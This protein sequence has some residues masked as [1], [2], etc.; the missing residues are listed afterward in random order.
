MIAELPLPILAK[1]TVARRLLSNRSAIA[2][3]A[4][5]LAIIIPCV[6]APLFAPYDPSVQP[7]IIGLRSQGPTVAHPFGTDPFSRDVLS[8]VLYGGRVSL[9]VALVATLVSITL[10]TAYGAIAGF[11]GGVV[12]SVMMRILDGLLSIPRLLLLIAIFAAWRQLPPAAFV[13]IIGLTGWYGLS[14]IVRGQVLAMK[15]EEFVVS[16]RALGAG[17]AR[18]LLRHILPNIL[19]PVIVAAALG[20]GHVI[21]L[22]A[23]LSYLGIGVQQP[24]PSWGN[25]IQDGSDQIAGQWWISFFPGMAIVLTVMAFNVL[26]DALREALQPRHMGAE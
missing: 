8:R 1:R 21:L 3:I 5:L 23:G 19:T 9:A 7:D 20:V 6:A 2:A 11:A 25:I 13:G 15:G 10:G 14:R 24:G 4:L 16:A 12:E 26:G 17:R 18:I 22:E